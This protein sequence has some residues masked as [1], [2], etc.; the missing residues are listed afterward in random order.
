MVEVASN[1]ATAMAA[2][3]AAGWILSQFDV[4]G[5]HTDYTL[6]SLREPST[7]VLAV[8]LLAMASIRKRTSDPQQV[9]SGSRLIWA[10][11]SPRRK[12][13]ARFA[14]ASDHRPDKSPSLFPGFRA[15]VMTP[16]ASLFWVFVGSF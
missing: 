13:G 6:L 10:L 16:D 7:M 4:Q 15:G 3:V 5:T 11:R 14:T 2:R 8:W 9:T 1:V 12:C